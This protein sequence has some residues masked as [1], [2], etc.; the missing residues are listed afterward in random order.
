MKQ[1]LQDLKLDTAK[2]PLGLLQKEK[3]RKSHS[4]LLEIQKLLIKESTGN[5]KQ[6]TQ[7]QMKELINDY[8]KTLPYDFGVKKAE[9]LF[10]L[11]KIKEETR[12][13]DQISD[14]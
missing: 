10:N 2:I 13:L 12:K 9:T 11:L 7:D 3:I 6:K 4:F 8:Y 5:N 1:V 14:I